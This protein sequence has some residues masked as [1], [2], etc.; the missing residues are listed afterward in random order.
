TLRASWWWAL[1]SWRGTRRMTRA[2]SSWLS[3]LRPA[4]AWGWMPRW[5]IALTALAPIESALPKLAG[6]DGS[7]GHPAGAPLRAREDPVSGPDGG[8]CRQ[9]DPPRR[10]AARGP[11]LDERS[12]C[13]LGVH[14]SR[15]GAQQNCLR[16]ALPVEH[17]A[18]RALTLPLRAAQNGRFSAGSLGP[19]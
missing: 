18:V 10:T 17:T 6:Q 12:L 13:R 5:A 8:H 1:T 2:A 15:L 4:A 7:A 14:G 3:R 16:S 19:A 9:P 11:I